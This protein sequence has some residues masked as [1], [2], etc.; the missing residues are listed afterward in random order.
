MRINHVMSNVMPARRQNL[1]K[2]VKK[3]IPLQL[4]T[5]DLLLL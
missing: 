3:S 1:S 2:S 5:Q 4:T